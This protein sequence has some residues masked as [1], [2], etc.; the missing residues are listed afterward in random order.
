[1]KKSTK[2]FKTWREKL[3]PEKAENLKAQRRAAYLKWQ[4]KIAADPEAKEKEK[5][6]HR[7][8]AL[9][10]FKKKKELNPEAIKAASRARYAW[11]KANKTPWYLNKLNYAREYRQSKKTAE[12]VAAFLAEVFA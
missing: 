6:K 4:A 7:G 8:V 11:H 9:K 1:M 5:I 12:N 3:T 10:S 2:Y